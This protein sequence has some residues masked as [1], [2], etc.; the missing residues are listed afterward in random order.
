MQKSNNTPLK[1]ELRQPMPETRRQRR[2]MK[3][4]QDQYFTLKAYEVN[5]FFETEQF[6]VI[7]IHPDHVK[8]LLLQC[9]EELKPE[10]IGDI[11]MLNFEEMKA[12][13][14]SANEE[15]ELP[16][17]TLYDV[18]KGYIGHG[19]IVCSTMWED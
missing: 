17:S 13:T 16:E 7:A 5:V 10:D 11:R 1:S 12:I 3:R 8:E 2:Y 14:I 9:P 19:E 18:F 6:W 4:K 15:M